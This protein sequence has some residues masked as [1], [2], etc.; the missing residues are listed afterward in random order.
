M[1]KKQ[2]YILLAIFGILAA[3]IFL[4]S[5]QTPR[6]LVA[7]DTQTLDFSFDQARAAKIII[8]RAGKEE[9]MALKQQGIW[10]LPQLWNAKAAPEKIADFLG[11]LARARGEVRADD[12]ALL[13][14]F[15]ITEDSALA[16]QLQDESG[17]GLL[18]L[19][20]GTKRAA[21]GSVFLRR[22]G[23]N[24]VFLSDF[25]LFRLLG[26]YGDAAQEPIQPRLWADLE[27][28]KVRPADVKTIEV[29]RFD[30]KN[31]VTAVQLKHAPGEKTPWAFGAPYEGFSLDSDKADTF[32]RALTSLRAS[33]VTDP[34]ASYGFDLPA[35][36][37]KIQ[38]A[39]GD[40]VLTVGQENADKTTR[41]LR[42]EG[43]LSASNAET[44][45]E[46]SRFSVNELS[47]DDSRFFKAGL[48][49]VAAGSVEAVILS[50]QGKEKR[51]SAADGESFEAVIRTLTQLE[52]PGL[53]LSADEKK[54]ARSPGLDQVT[55]ELKGGQKMILDFG[56]QLE[57]DGSLGARYAA[58]VRGKP[59][60]FTVSAV[61]YEALFESLKPAE[62]KASQPALPEAQ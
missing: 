52:I 40:R 61:D 3:G 4:R 33:G 12:A 59:L 22:A 37:I 42:V 24:T 13:A 39:E 48:P 30:G 5:L 50:K 6:G 36:Q 55:L 35:L 25:D 62:T 56:E 19:R 38:T 23:S 47:A 26:I 32:L 43:D 29:L 44:A 45:Y 54:R 21:N 34:A 7:E 31:P 16:I 11:G 18:D 15:G 17:A 27:P 20:A 28:V 46:I 14:D 60:L 51:L 10:I 9:L 58:S 2:I 8:S 41:A 57:K 1:T 53:L 49:G